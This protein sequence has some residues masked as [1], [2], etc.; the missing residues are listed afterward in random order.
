MGKKPSIPGV[1][2]ARKSKEFEFDQSEEERED[3]VGYEDEDEVADDRG[4]DLREKS[5]KNTQKK[6]NENRKEVLPLKSIM[7]GIL[8]KIKAPEA[9][10][11]SDAPKVEDAKRRNRF[12]SQRRN[13]F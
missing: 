11:S 12:S 9:S 2:S 5:L 10:S 7:S 13:R 6:A 1:V 3:N 8:E 4:F